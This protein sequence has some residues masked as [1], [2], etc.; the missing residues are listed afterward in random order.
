MN[1]V[2][3]AAP[4]AAARPSD[5]HESRRL[6]SLVAAAVLFV[7]CFLPP[8]A[9][10]SRRYEFAE[11]LVFGLLAVAVPALVVAGAPWRRLR[12]ADRSAPSDE[13][14]MTTPVGDLR[15]VDRLALGRRRHLE[16]VRTVAFAIL[17][18]GVAVLWRIPLTVD[19]LRHHPWLL[20][21]EALMLVATGIGLWCELI[22]SPP[23]VPRLSRP[24]RI[25]LA[26]ISM[27]TIWV[28]AYLVG[29][30]HGSWY[31]AYPHYA[32][33]GL[34]TSAD[35]QLTTG[36]LWFVS[37]C[38]F[39]PVVYWNLMRWLQAEENPDDELHRLNREER[40]R[41]GSLGS[42]SPTP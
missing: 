31:T 22:E 4:P 13:A 16:I 24:H 20:P 34:S 11:A 8:L 28:L 17:F 14:L 39:I 9:S 6:L 33:R 35:Q 30:A 12:L 36:V 5:P 21:I 3:G 18:L 41:G 10:W 27:W 38:A 29:M 15:P 37:G 25:A 23:L 7:V 40:I 32:G 2:D 1:P 19:A 26:A 42:H